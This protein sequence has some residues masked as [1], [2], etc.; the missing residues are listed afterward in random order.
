M[1]ISEVLKELSC[2]DQTA[3]HE[4]WYNCYI[5]DRFS[6]DRHHSL[7]VAKIHAEYADKQ[8]SGFL[9]TLHVLRDAKGNETVEVVK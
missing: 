5:G 8:R 9:C 3:E 2:T 7:F 4:A 1:R 6:L